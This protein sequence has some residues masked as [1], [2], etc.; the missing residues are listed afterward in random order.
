MRKGFSLVE[1]LVVLSI[2][3]VIS[4][5]VLF[6]QNKFSSDTNITN[7]A[8]EIALVARNA[9]SYGLSIK[10]S[11]GVGVLTDYAYGIYFAPGLP[12]SSFTLFY[13]QNNNRVYDALGD[14]K[15]NTYLVQNGNEISSIC[16]NNSSTDCTGTTGDY[17]N[18]TFLRPNPNANIRAYIGGGPVLKTSVEI[19][20]RSAL[21]DRTKTVQ[22]TNTGQISVK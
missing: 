1:L 13:D 20:V 17:S 18:I 5:V 15:I 2:F 14:I 7:L 6:S 3:I 9:Q 10:A 22:I 16:F 8:Y 4:S 19:T 12:L 21:K 11:N